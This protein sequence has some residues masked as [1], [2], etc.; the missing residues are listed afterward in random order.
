M[1]IIK[2]VPFT[3]DKQHYMNQNNEIFI[4]GVAQFIT[5]APSSLPSSS[6]TLRKNKKQWDFADSNH[7][8]YDL[9][10]YALP[11]ELKS[12]T[13]ARRNLIFLN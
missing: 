6:S 13:F 12:L 10:S 11:G 4:A 2:I 1:Q 7:V 8:P 5:V 3:L 9:Q